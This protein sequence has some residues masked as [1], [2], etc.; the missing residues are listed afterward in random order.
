MEKLFKE[1]AEWIA[2]SI[3]AIGILL[4][5]IGGLQAFLR[6]LV[7][8]FRAPMAFGWRRKVWVDLG[9]WLMLSLQFLLGADI[10][11]SAI[12]P[13]W[14]TIGQLAAIAAIR[15][16]LNYFLEKD[17]EKM[18]SEDADTVRLEPGKSR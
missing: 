2:L 13:T 3:E 12:A 16:F 6:V 9:V 1:C 14:T 15:T 5:A 17:I 4:I 10:V 8:F 7:D 11:R 18:R